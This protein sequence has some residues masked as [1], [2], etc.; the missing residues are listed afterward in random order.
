M[1]DDFDFRPSAGGQ[2]PSCT[3]PRPLSPPPYRPFRT[4]TRRPPC[5]DHTGR[6]LA[7]AAF[8]PGQLC[9]AGLS[10]R[11][12]AAG[13]PAGPY[14]LYAAAISAGLWP[15]SPTLF[16]LSEAAGLYAAPLWVSGRF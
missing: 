11:A 4:F 1:P 6:S 15:A 10:R 14:A 12:P 9:A 13:L 2:E 8:R 16:L 3:P 7:A 5:P